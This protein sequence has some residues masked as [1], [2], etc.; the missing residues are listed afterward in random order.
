VISGCSKAARLSLECV[1]LM[2]L[3][4]GAEVPLAWPTGPAAVRIDYLE[5]ISSPAD[6][7]IRRGFF[8]RFADLVFGPG[9]HPRGLVRPFSIAVD[10]E[11]RLLVADLACVHVLDPSHRK[12]KILQGPGREPLKSPIGLDADAAGNI[13][14]S[15][16]ALGKIFVFDKEGRF[17]RFLGDARGEGIFKRPTGLA[18]DRAAN[19]IYLTDTL[20]H[21]VY[22]L[23]T[24]G[25]TER[26]WGGRG[27]G[28]GEF[29]FPI[30][31]TV[32]G[33][34]VYVLDAMNFR[35]QVFTPTGAFVSTFGSPGN[36]PGR[37]F[38]PKALAADQKNRLV[39]VV[40][41]MFEV[42]QAFTFAGDLV[43]A[44]GAPG[45]GPGEFRLPA[46]ICVE[47]GGRILVADSYNARIQVFHPLKP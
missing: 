46:G 17:L 42:V 21:K 43:V 14:V 35:V 9:E 19:R 10:S 28:P 41:A 16:S 5:S 2:G 3:A 25:S 39:F 7:S 13:Y 44:F 34:R 1:L 36:A 26:E 33:D 24:N 30:A 23:H 38:R 6:L 11:K 31:V 40:D 12:H 18:V 37:F 47:P 20:R 32:A 8:S 27:E 22:V 45:S 29:N 15:D 4:L